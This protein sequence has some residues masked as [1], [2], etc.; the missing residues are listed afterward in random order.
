M[1]AQATAAGKRRAAATKR[2]WAD[3]ESDVELGAH[4]FVA[5]LADVGDPRANDD[6]TP[7]TT[8]KTKRKTNKKNPAA[9]RK[10]TRGA[11]GDLPAE[12]EDDGDSPPAVQV[13]N[14]ETFWVAQLQDDLTSD[15]VDSDT[16]VHI[17]WLNKQANGQF[18]YAYEDWL[19]VRSILCPIYVTPVH[20]R[21][22][23]TPKSLARVSTVA[24]VT[25]VAVVD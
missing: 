14:E 10:S 16:L 24:S 9:T 3:V 19:D 23:I 12:H 21:F 5:V 4:E 1:Q 8:K 18:A 13:A 6:H 17:T 7:N 15:M 20:D 11:K 2:K 25:C 22:E